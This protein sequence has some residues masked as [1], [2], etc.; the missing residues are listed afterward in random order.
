MEYLDI[1][2]LYWTRVTWYIQLFLQCPLKLECPLRYFQLNSIIF[3]TTHYY[4]YQW[5]WNVV[6]IKKVPKIVGKHCEQSRS[7]IGIVDDRQSRT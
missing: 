2:N 1:I 4:N 3:T 5:C 6:L 7:L